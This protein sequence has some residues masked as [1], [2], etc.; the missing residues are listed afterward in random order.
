MHST[1]FRNLR[2]IGYHILILCHDV[3]HLN[4]MN[5]KSIRAISA[6]RGMNTPNSIAEEREL[7]TILQRHERVLAD[8][9]T[10]WCG[11]CLRMDSTIADLTAEVEQPI[12]K[13]DVKECPAL[14]PKYDIGPIP[15]FFVFENGEPIDTRVGVTDKTTLKELC[16]E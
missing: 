1:L 5:E 12:L 14:A 9:H 15:A 6:S 4:S 8:Y 3:Q 11:S 7:A 16:S 10:T 2:I 13:I